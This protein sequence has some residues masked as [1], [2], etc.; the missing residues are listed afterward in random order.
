MDQFL[1]SEA[2]FNGGSSKQFVDTYFPDTLFALSDIIPTLMLK[3]RC[4]YSAH[5]YFG[6]QSEE[7]NHGFPVHVHTQIWIR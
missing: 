3:R 1:M 5:W 2:F 7:R 6:K 4:C